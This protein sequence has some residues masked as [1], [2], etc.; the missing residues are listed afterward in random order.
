MLGY[1]AYR[2]EVHPGHLLQAFALGQSAKGAIGVQWIDSANIDKARNKL[3]HT[4]IVKGCDWLLMCD[5][6]TYYPRAP[7]I[8][9]MIGDADARRAAVVAAPVRLRNREGRNVYRITGGEYSQL[10]PEEYEGRLVDVEAIGTAFMAIR[11][12]FVVTHMK[13]PWFQTVQTHEGPVE[14]VGED[15]GFCASVKTAGGSILCDGR[16]E[17]AHVGT[18]SE[19][20]GWSEVSR[21]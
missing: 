2:Q 16:F 4:A 9:R 6:D 21:E 13:R 19:S 12:G 5:A 3:L 10:R 17:P 8:L 7:D 1:P 15:L 18:I 14:S 11:C 20:T